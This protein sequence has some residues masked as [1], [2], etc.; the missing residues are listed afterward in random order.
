M[1]DQYQMPLFHIIYLLRQ[2]Y[3]C[4][5]STLCISQTLFDKKVKTN[6]KLCSCVRHFLRRCCN[7][8]RFMFQINIQ[9]LLIMETV[10]ER[11]C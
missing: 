8:P 7:I 11:H 4:I 9:V 5:Y 6:G 3:A 10:I 1:L 2:P